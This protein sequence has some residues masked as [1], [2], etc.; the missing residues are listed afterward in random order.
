M[1]HRVRSD[2]D[3]DGVYHSG[4]VIERNFLACN[5]NLFRAHYFY[6]TFFIHGNYGTIRRDSNGI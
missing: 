6:S 5:E 2:P 1:E 3:F 4:N